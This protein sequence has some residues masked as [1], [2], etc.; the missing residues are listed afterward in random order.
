MTPDTWSKVFVN[1]VLTKFKLWKAE[2][3]GTFT[4]IETVIPAPSL[5]ADKETELNGI[6]GPDMQ[7]LQESG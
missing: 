7:E 2:P 1:G 4:W 6:M 3:D 5:V